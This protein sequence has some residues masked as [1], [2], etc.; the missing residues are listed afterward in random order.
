MAGIDEKV[1]IDSETGKTFTIDGKVVYLSYPP[2]FVS[3]SPDP[4]PGNLIVSISGWTGQGNTVNR[5]HIIPKR[6]GGWPS[7]YML[8]FPYLFV[9]IYALGNT[10]Y[11]RGW[12]SHVACALSVNP[13]GEHTGLFGE[14]WPRLYMKGP[15]I[16]V[17]P[18]K[19]MTGTGADNATIECQ[20][21]SV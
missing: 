9:W 10:G 12:Y 11:G 6:A 15:T 14:F 13:R 19:E 18:M 4:F 21:W 3:I 17:Y 7:W 20:G 1:A 16:G 5:T 8:W 2:Y